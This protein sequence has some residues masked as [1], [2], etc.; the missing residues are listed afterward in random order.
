MNRTD[1]LF[2]ILLELQANPHI[3]AE[4]LARR[5]EVTRRTIYRDVLALNEAGVPVVATPGKGY[6]VVEGYFLPPVN[7]TSNEATMLILGA[8]FVSQNFDQEYRNAAHS[9]KRKIETVLSRR[10]REFVRSLTRRM[11]FHTMTPLNDPKLIET[12]RKV[13][14]ALLEQ[15]TIRFLYF[16]RFGGDGK[17]EP[18]TVNPLLLSYLSGNW[19]LGGWDHRRKSLRTFRLSRMEQLEVTDRVFVP[20]KK[21]KPSDWAKD[22]QFGAEAELLFDQSVARWVLES[23]P[24]FVS[25]RTKTPRGLRVSIRTNTLDQVIPWILSWG[26]SVHVLSPDSLRLRILEENRLAAERNSQS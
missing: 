3:R 12:L 19:L 8:D 1:R 24:W 4:D 22:Q 10:H 23:P 26:R 20:P 6:A 14:R 11:S 5:F 9:A 25:R 21:F 17:P 18:R 2:A 7:L 15:R 13:R 16:K